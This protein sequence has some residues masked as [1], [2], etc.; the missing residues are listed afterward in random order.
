MISKRTGVRQP[1]CSDLFLTTVGIFSYYCW[2]VSY[3]SGS[4]ENLVVSVSQWITFNDCI[5]PMN[6]ILWP[7]SFLAGTWQDFNVT[8][9]HVWSLQLFIL[10]LCSLSINVLASVDFKGFLNL[11][12]FPCLWFK[13]SISLPLWLYYKL[14]MWVWRN[15]KNQKHIFW[16]LCN[17]WMGGCYDTAYFHSTIGSSLEFLTDCPFCSPLYTGRV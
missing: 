17:S 4:V 7:C 3:Y 10:L 1:I 5:I 8:L 13:W 12:K 6:A 2:T 16:V 14:I 11:S 15:L 9:C